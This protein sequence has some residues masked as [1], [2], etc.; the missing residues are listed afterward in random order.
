MLAYTGRE[1]LSF[2]L[3]LSLS[4]CVFFLSAENE[5]GQR[6]EAPATRLLYPSGVIHFLRRSLIRPRARALKSEFGMSA[7]EKARI[8]AN[9]ES[10][11]VQNNAAAAAARGV[12]L[13]GPTF[14][15]SVIRYTRMSCFH[16]RRGARSRSR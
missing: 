9:R 12:S 15:V 10:P 6:A 5:L 3:S 11:A 4:V 8:A 14:A 2:S 13:I 16:F 1:G 7:W